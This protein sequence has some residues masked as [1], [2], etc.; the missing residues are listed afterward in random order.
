MLIKG[1]AHIQ[2]VLL[3]YNLLEKYNIDKIGVFGSVARGEQAQDIDLFVEDISDYNELMKFKEELERILEVK[4]DIMIKKFANPI[5]LY[6]AQK[7]MIYVT[8]H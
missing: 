1:V 2:K 5:V 3:Q 8:G 4:V 6:R 7:E